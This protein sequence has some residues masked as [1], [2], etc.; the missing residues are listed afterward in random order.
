VVRIDCGT[1]DPFLPTA[2]AFAA[3]LPHAN[4]GGFS[5]GYHDA[6]YWRSVAPAQIDTI[7]GALFGK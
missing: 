5:F 7:A 6:P 4:P 3:K 1:K 2:K